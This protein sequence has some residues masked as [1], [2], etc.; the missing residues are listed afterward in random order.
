MNM[1]QITNEQNNNEP[2]QEKQYM[3]MCPVS[4][5]MPNINVDPT[6]NKWNETIVDHKDKLSGF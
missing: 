1:H 2:K 4:I 5:T 6:T 3:R